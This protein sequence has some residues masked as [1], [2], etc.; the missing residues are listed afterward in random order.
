MPN[1]LPS[2]TLA[3]AA[4]WRQWLAQNNSASP[5]VWLTIARK[6]MQPTTSITYMEALEE[7]LCYGW[8]D[9]QGKKLNGQTDLHTYRFTPRRPKGLWSKRNVGF[10]GRLESEGRM[11]PAGLAAV[12]AAKADGRWDAAYSGSGSA[13]MS[14]DFLAA[15]KEC[16]E[17][18]S[19]F[20]GLNKGNRWAI[21]FRLINLKTQA[22][23]EKCIKGF[24]EML[25]RGG[26]PLAQKQKQPS[27]AVKSSGK[28]E[29]TSLAD[30]E[31]LEKQPIRRTRSGRPAPLYVGSD[32]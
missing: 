28:R 11:Q 7:A 17:A 10:V 5:G 1:D 31:E 32:K 19:T 4:L 18:Q 3:N 25:G 13:E 6:P 22:G 14:A 21:Y 9:S 29:R 20:D 24:V 15:L 16:P 12:E 30:D 2:L 23:R 8:I 26:T 27:S